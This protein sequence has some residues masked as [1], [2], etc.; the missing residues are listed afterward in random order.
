MSARP[1]AE[2]RNSHVSH[3]SRVRR[4]VMAAG[5]AVGAIAL[6]AACDPMAGKP[7]PDLPRPSTSI[8]IDPLPSEAPTSTVAP[9]TTSSSAAAPTTTTA[10]PSVS[11]SPKPQP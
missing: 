3:V 8:T 6:T 5:V 7:A 10:K 1:S 4:I 11:T 9:T 2:L